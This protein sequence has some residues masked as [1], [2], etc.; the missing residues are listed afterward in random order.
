M[1]KSAEADTK[2]TPKETAAAQ[3]KYYTTSIYGTLVTF[4]NTVAGSAALN[5]KPLVNLLPRRPATVLARA[6]PP[7]EPVEIAPVTALTR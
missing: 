2:A 3:G 1:K 5:E 6:V 7:V 4:I